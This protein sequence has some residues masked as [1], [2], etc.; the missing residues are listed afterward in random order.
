MVQ[1]NN[2]WYAE[3]ANDAARKPVLEKVHLKNPS[4]FQPSA[5]EV[6]GLDSRAKCNGSQKFGLDLDLPG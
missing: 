5:R 1:V 6:D 4:E 2:H 3:L